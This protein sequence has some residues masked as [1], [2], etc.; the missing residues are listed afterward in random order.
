MISQS[1]REQH[2]G[3]ADAKAEEGLAKVI[4][5]SKYRKSFKERYESELL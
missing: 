4:D 1:L 5:M 2:Q 3:E